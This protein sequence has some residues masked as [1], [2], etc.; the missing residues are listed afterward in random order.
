VSFIAPFPGGIN[1]LS[2]SFIG[3]QGGHSDTFTF[4]AAYGGRVLVAVCTGSN[5]TNFNITGCTIGGVSATKITSSSENG[6]SGLWQCD[7]VFWAVVP[8]NADQS[9][10]FS[11]NQSILQSGIALYELVGA[12]AALNTQT[13]SFNGASRSSISTTFTAPWGACVLGSCIE[14]GSSI[15]A[16]NLTVDGNI[17]VASGEHFVTASGASVTSPG[18]LN[19]ALQPNTTSTLSGWFVMFTP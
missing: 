9:V 10:S 2:L 1:P 14:Y 4:P 7:A 18:S 3:I 17:T 11:A 15:S 12:G 16:T 19:V 5:T 13:A 8:T 6:F